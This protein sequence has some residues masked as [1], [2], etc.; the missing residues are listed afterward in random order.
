[1]KNLNFIC[2]F[3]SV[4]ILQLLYNIFLQKIDYLYSILQ[5]Y[6]HL[7]YFSKDVLF[8]PHLKLY[9]KTKTPL[10]DTKEY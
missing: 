5:K 10:L 6:S 7:I 8:L 3:F 1:M 2:K 4:Q 9:K